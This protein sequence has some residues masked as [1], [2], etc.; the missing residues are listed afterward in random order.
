MSYDF[1]TG[2]VPRVDELSG[3]FSFA[4]KVV[5]GAVKVGKKVAKKKAAPVV[6]VPALKKKYRSPGA[7]TYAPPLRDGPSIPDYADEMRRIREE[8]AQAPVFAPQ[9]TIYLPAPQSSGSSPAYSQDQSAPI[10]PAATAWF[11]PV[12]IAGALLVFFAGRKGR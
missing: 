11:I 9:P 2:S 12:A 8:Q 3:V 6:A 10:A 7:P 5:K 4:K 1:I